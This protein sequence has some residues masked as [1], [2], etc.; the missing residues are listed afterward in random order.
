MATQ[1]GP[2]QRI[3]C[4]PVKCAPDS[5]KAT[6]NEQRTRSPPVPGSVSRW[7]SRSD[8][9]VARWISGGWEERTPAPAVRAY[10]EAV[11]GEEAAEDA[12]LEPCPQHDD[13]VLDVHGGGDRIAWRAKSDR[14]RERGRGR[15]R[16]N[17][18]SPTARLLKR[19]G[20]VGGKEMTAVVRVF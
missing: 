18:G 1:K 8:D 17:C 9:P 2:I 15:V 14:W 11:D 13:V 16:G 6:G 19:K 4:V 12:L 7:G 5:F 10:L 3:I 20:G